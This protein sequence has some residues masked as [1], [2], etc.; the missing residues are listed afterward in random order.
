[1]LNQQRRLPLAQRSGYKQQQQQE[2]GSNRLIVTQS[3]L[4]GTTGI[5]MDI[6]VTARRA[7]TVMLKAK[8]RRG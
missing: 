7:L 5:L 8:L 1:V 4:R 3:S 6:P 2:G